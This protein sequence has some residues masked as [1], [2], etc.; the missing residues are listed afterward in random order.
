MAKQIP[1]EQ[2]F[3]AA[4]ETISTRGY[5]GATTKQIAA[6]AGINEVTLFRRFGTK[7]KLLRGALAAEVGRFEA[8]GGA[9]HTGDLRQDLIRVV[10]LYQ[11]LVVRS[12]RLLPVVLAEL[13]RDPA[14]RE[15]IDLPQAV[16]RAIATLLERYQRE[17]LLRP[18]PPLQAVAALLGPVLV[19]ALVVPLNTETRP[20]ALDPAEH[21]DRYLVGRGAPCA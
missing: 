11:E 5:A 14:L 16:I 15:A 1:D 17:G 3:D 13:P 4:L 19:V 18:E 21:V 20:P 2:I 7:A 12:G 9:T 6:T 10:A 8:A